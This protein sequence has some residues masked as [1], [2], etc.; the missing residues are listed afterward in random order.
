MDIEQEVCNDLKNGSKY[1]KLSRLLK[2]NFNSK[3]SI[4]LIDAFRSLYHGQLFLLIMIF[5][6]PNEFRYRYIALM[7][8]SFYL[9]RLN[10]YIPSSLSLILNK[11]MKQEKYVLYTKST[12]TRKN[13]KNL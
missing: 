13:D 7:C 9:N 10:A 11:L 12:R 5:Y 2:F 4:F 8:K 6:L 1:Y 3:K